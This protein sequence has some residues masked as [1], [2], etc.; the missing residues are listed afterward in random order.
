MFMDEPSRAPVNHG[1]QVKETCMQ[2]MA[3]PQ[4]MDILEIF[5]EGMNN[6][7]CQINNHLYFYPP[8]KYKS[9]QSVRL[10]V[11]P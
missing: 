11:S 2:T 4:R 8:L 1:V 3:I 7:G 6:N 10:L 5:S 9:T